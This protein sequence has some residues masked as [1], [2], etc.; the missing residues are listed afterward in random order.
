MAFHSNKVSRL[1]TLCVFSLSL[2]LVYD[3][4]INLPIYFHHCYIVFNVKNF[5]PRH[6]SS[7]ITDICNIK[8]ISNEHQETGTRA[9][10]VFD[11]YFVFLHE[12]VFSLMKRIFQGLL[13]VY[14]QQLILLQN[15]SGN[16]FFQII[17]TTTATMTVINSEY[18]HFFVVWCQFRHY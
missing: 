14:L 16:V 1:P 5:L 17:S 7:G 3:L 12:F 8:L 18:R 11:N 6:N 2:H 13:R 4:L 15:E 10:S 9:R